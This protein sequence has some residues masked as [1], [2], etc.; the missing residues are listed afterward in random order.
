MVDSEVIGKIYKDLYILPISL[1]HEYLN[2]FL[3]ESYWGMFEG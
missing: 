2:E 3:T 1:A